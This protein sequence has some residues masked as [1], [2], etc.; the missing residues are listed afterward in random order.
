MAKIDVRVRGWGKRTDRA[1]KLKKFW[2]HP[3][4]YAGRQHPLN[5]QIHCCYIVKKKRQLIPNRGNCW[6]T[7]TGKTTLQPSL[8][9]HRTKI[10]VG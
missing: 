2:V 5:Q 3:P 7:G 1:R 4:I 9:A 6:R 8:S 10:G